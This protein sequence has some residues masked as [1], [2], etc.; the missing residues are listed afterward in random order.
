MNKG[1]EAELIMDGSKR[2]TWGL[3]ECG[4]TVEVKGMGIG[5]AVW[6]EK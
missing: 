1:R 5:F 3:V 4:G 6:A 2:L